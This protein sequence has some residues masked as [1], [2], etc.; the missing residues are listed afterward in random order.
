MLIDLL[1]KKLAAG[2]GASDFAVIKIVNQEI[3]RYFEKVVLEM[4][5][6]QNMLGK[7]KSS[8]AGNAAV[9]RGFFNV[10]AELRQEMGMNNFFTK[11]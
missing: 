2:G 4:M 9:Q 1:W 3:D 10:C 11:I 5:L 6:V 8:F 7:S